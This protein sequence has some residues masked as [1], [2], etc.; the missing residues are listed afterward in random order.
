L[1]EGDVLPII[2]DL[3]S[4]SLKNVDAY[5]GG[6]AISALTYYYAVTQIG[7][8]SELRKGSKN[9]YTEYTFKQVGIVPKELRPQIKDYQKAI[10]A[11]VLQ[12]TPDSVGGTG[13]TVEVTGEMEDIE[14]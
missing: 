11:M 3:P 5:L 13:T 9:A 12:P 2:V 7:L 10:K 4:T 8:K 6:L 14:L 1:R